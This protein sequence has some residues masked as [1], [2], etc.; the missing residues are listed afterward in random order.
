MARGLLGTLLRPFVNVRREGMHPNR[1]HM[2]FVASLAA[3]LLLITPTVD[4]QTPGPLWNPMDLPETRGTVKQFTLTPRGDI[5]GL[6]LNDGTEVNLAPHLTSQIVF[7]IRPGDAVT[8]RGMRAASIPLVNAISITNDATRVTVTDNGPP[9]GPG[10]AGAEQT[11]SGRIATTLHGR[12]GEVNG[13]LLDNG[14]MLRLPPPEA[15]R[16]QQ[17]LQ[18]GQ[19]ISARG[20]VLS[21]PIGTVMD[22]AALG[23]SGQWWG[24]APPPPA[25]G[26]GP[27]DRGPPSADFGPLSPPPPRP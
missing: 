2:L 22:V 11:I 10:R 13:A 21:T 20:N 9:D 27:A 5:D 6:I 17:W 24:P 8:V 1:C 14:T 3:R 7:A 23:T 25:R 16:A 15:E 18:G 12:G 26:R 19:W 4:A